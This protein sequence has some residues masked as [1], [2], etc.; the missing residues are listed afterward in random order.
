MLAQIFRSFEGDQIKP[1]LCCV[2]VLMNVL[3]RRIGVA[4]EGTSSTVPGRLNP[5]G[6]LGAYVHQCQHVLFIQMPRQ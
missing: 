2:V 4:A 6:A 3:R 1:G 5:A